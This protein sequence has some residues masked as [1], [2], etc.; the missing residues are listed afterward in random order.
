MFSRFYW[1]PLRRRREKLAGLSR[2]VN[3][4]RQFFDNVMDSLC[5][6]CPAINSFAV[7]LFFFFF[8]MIL[9][10]SW[11]AVW[12]RRKKSTSDFRSCTIEIPSLTWLSP[13]MQLIDAQFSQQRRTVF[14]TNIC[15]RIL[16]RIAACLSFSAQR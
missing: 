16:M 12:R 3:N 2:A 13:V 14:V 9:S 10:P 15:T 4:Y 8:R 6:L 11:C 1:I 5:L 7:Y